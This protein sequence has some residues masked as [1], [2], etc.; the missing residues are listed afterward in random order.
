MVP[1]P[2][3]ALTAVGTNVADTV[4]LDGVV[5]TPVPGSVGALVVGDS[6]MSA[7]VCT[8]E[9][10]ADGGG[11]VGAGVSWPVGPRVVVTVVG[12]IDGATEGCWVGT[13]I[14]G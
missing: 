10:I 3:A 7:T 2:T 9:G 5:G 11:M 12:A 4:V 14:V 1:F 6:V 8:A 13:S